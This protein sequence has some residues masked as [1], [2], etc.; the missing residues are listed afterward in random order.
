MLLAY[1]GLLILPIISL[2]V[3]GISAIFFLYFWAGVVVSCINKSKLDDHDFTERMVYETNAPP[4]P[5]YVNEHF[6]VRKQSTIA[7]YTQNNM[8]SFYTQL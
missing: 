3:L 5:G 4:F 7:Y 6:E 8:M 1:V 2:I